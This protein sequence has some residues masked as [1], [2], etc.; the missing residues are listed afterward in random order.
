[1][2]TDKICRLGIA[3]TF[4]NIR[5]FPYLSVLDNV[6]I[7][8]HSLNHAFLWDALLKT[9]RFKREEA[10]TEAFAMQLLERIGLAHLR[11]SYARNLPYG[12]QRK[13]EIARALASKPKVLLLD[14]PAAGM[15]AV[16]TAQL[17][18]FIRELRDDG[19]TIVLIEHDMRLVMAIA[20]I[21][22]VIDHGVKIAEGDASTVQNDPRVIEAYLG[23]RAV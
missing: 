7:G 22:T 14:E 21:I 17:D 15:N 12:A 8:T 13:L 19:F 2:A 16:E 10:E 5:L 3:R 6:K 1:M 18:E 9:P 11:D 23:K 20:D 4:Q